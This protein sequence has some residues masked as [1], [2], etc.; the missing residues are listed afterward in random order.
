MQKKKAVSIVLILLIL[1]ITRS[2]GI[3]NIP[4]WAII[5]ALILCIREAVLSILKHKGSKKELVYT[6]AIFLILIT[7][8]IISIISVVIQNSYPQISLIYKPII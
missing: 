4:V 1:N 3:K 5:L 7:M 6:M 2:M 8:G